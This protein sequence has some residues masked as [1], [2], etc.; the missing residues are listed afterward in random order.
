MCVTVVVIESW[1]NVWHSNHFRLLVATELSAMQLSSAMTLKQQ[2]QTQ[3]TMTCRKMQN[4]CLGFH[5][6]IKKVTV[7]L[8]P[9]S[10]LF[11]NYNEQL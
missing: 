3:T 9:V 8:E 1:L 5:K 7:Q 10:Y 4:L 2:Q 6:N 11:K